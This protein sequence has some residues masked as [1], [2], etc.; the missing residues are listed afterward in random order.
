MKDNYL[1]SIFTENGTGSQTANKVL[2]RA[3]LL[4][5]LE[6]S[7]KN[8]F[9]SNIA[10]LPTEY[11]IR[12]NSKSYS[13]FSLNDKINLCVLFNKKTINK[14]LA[15]INKETL[16]ITNKD[17]K[18]D[19]KEH[20]N[21]IEIPCRSLTKELHDS[22]STRKLL[23][24]ML[25]VG[26]VARSL[27]INLE[28]LS[29]AAVTFL[30]HLKKE[31]LEANLKALKVGYSSLNEDASIS[32]EKPEKKPLSHLIDGNSAM[33]LG[34]LD[35][36]TDIFTWYPI[37]PSS[38]VAESFDKFNKTLKQN[39]TLLQVEDELAAVTACLGA[40]WAGAKSVTAT[41]GP[42]LS[43]M[44][45]SIGLAYYTETPL[46]VTDIQRAG[47]STGLPTRTSQGDLLSAY[48]SSHGDTEHP[49]LL[50]S[51]PQQA[52]D[53]AF[54][55]LSLSQDIQS[56]VFV[57]SDLDLGM[58][59]WSCSNLKQFNQDPSKGLFQ[60]DPVDGEF[61][62]FSNDDLVSKRSLPYISDISTSYF[63]R[64]SGHDEYG[65]Y[66]ED[67]NTY[68]EKLKRLKSKIKNLRELTDF[69]PKDI[70]FDNKSNY[71]LIY[72]GSTT[73]IV[74]ELKDLLIDFNVSLYQVRALPI[75]KELNAFINNHENNFV[76][77]QNRDG[78]LFKIIKSNVKTK[79]NLIS[80]TQFNG[81]P[82]DPVHFYKQIIGGHR[83]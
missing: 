35:G 56:P 77:E 28:N 30:S 24:N 10:G 1:I 60:V 25:Y 27:N 21:I 64:G 72:Y 12:I 6:Q 79:S 59:E 17:Y 36:G 2:S 73:Q 51:N 41:S 39:R 81:Y 66:S 20:N 50:P 47:P 29:K 67:P 65:N 34:F 70:V 32:L 68:S 13:S 78:Q 18:F 22:V 9:P 76:V 61:K 44:Q 5:G 74:N 8:L 58:N 62:P 11:R 46:V 71:S 54:S 37:T 38:S 43:L 52:Y 49:V 33:A 14:D 19:F 31:I 80:C 48:Y 63:T 40:G 55:S 23:Y 75:D 82:A 42:G 45:E 3:L 83:L 15:L 4:E 53:D 69:T 16:I 57:L 26:V 7:S